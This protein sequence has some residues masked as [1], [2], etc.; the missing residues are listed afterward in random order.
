YLTT[1]AKPLKLAFT[2]T[3]DGALLSRAVFSLDLPDVIAPNSENGARVPV[4]IH[5]SR[6]GWVLIFIRADDANR[7]SKMPAQRVPDNHQLQIDCRFVRGRNQSGPTTFHIAA[8][9]FDQ[10]DEPLADQTDFASP[11]PGDVQIS[12]TIIVPARVDDTRKLE[13][14]Y[15]VRDE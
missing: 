7:W 10:V 2:A 8:S 1:V 14:I 11:P 12:R 15:P 6:R 13:F 3:P 9:L 5:S 4:T